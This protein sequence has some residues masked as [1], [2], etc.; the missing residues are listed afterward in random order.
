MQRRRCRHI[1]DDTRD[2]IIDWLHACWPNALCDEPFVNGLFVI[3]DDAVRE[4][5]EAERER[6]QRRLHRCLSQ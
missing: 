5:V 4:A 3:C 2:I 6:Q 1:T